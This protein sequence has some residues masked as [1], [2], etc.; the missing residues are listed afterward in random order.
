MEPVRAGLL[1]AGLDVLTSLA[2]PT[3]LMNRGPGTLTDYGNGDKAGLW[4]IGAGQGC[5]WPD[6]AL[7]L[8]CRCM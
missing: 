2:D 4:W 8:N 6:P 5:N 3:Q 7:L 1:A